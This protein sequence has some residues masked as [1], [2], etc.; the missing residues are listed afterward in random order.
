MNTSGPRVR[1]E[2]G[3]RHRALGSE[4]LAVPA[5]RVRLDELEQRLGALELSIGAG[6]VPAAL[7]WDAGRAGAR[8]PRMLEIAVLTGTPLVLLWLAHWLIMAWFGHLNARAMLSASVAIPLPFGFLAAAGGLQRPK[9]WFLAS[10]VV[11]FVATVGM[12]LVSVLMQ[13]SELI[14]ASAHDAHEFLTHMACITLSFAAGLSLGLAFWQYVTRRDAARSHARWQ[15]RVASFLVAGHFDAEHAH[16]ATVELLR[17]M[18][19]VT[20]LAAIAGSIYS[21]WLRFFT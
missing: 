9:T 11:G 14:P 5:L 18:R 15:Y 10:I 4:D 17:I 7:A 13:M 12:H 8:R 1:G 21:G 2:S 6:D 3:G 16:R 20:A 19:V